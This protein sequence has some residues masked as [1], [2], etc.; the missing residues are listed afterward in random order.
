MA[1]LFYERPVVL[2]TDRHRNLRML[3]GEAQFG[4][5]RETN[6]VPIVTSEFASCVGHYPIV[7]AGDDA[8]AR[9]PVA[10]LGIRDRENLF[11]DAEG[12]WDAEYIPAFVR[13]YPF[14]LASSVGETNAQ[15][16]V[17]FDESFAGLV[18]SSE[19]VPLFDDNGEPAA[20]LQGALAFLRD[21]QARLGVTRS[22]MAQLSELDLLVKRHLKIQRPNGD[23]FRLDGFYIVDDERLRALDDAQVLSLFRSGAL[24]WIEAH[25]FSLS[26][27]GAL[28]ARLDRLQGT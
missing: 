28:S 14:V 24:D 11:V 17:C 9:M 8:G 20:F 13:R 16:N 6:S 4:F 2:D 1:V 26:R 22:F 25:R 15:F 3:Q 19:G 27:I 7:F 12:H 18:E 5:A 21:Y 23:E 10:L